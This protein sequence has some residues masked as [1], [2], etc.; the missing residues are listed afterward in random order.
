MR[1]VIDTSIIID[2]IRGG[3]K[4]ENF[5]KNIS[6]DSEF[7]LPTIV[8]Y[9]LFSGES[10]RQALHKKVITNFLRHFRRIELNEE[11]AIVAGELYRDVSK[12]LGVGD[13]IIAASALA[14]NAEVLTINRKHFQQIPNLKLYDLLN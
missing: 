13:Y 6:E 8:I 9:E 2:Y 5:I 3:S 7:Y 1:V 11:I 10:T 12:I 14:I 4:W